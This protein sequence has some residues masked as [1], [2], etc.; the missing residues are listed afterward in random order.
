MP[1]NMAR[2]I[3]GETSLWDAGIRLMQAG[4]PE[5][6]QAIVDAVRIRRENLKA[7]TE[8][9][10]VADKKMRPTKCTIRVGFHNANSQ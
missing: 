9:E 7:I 5:E 10:R 6:W 4:N 1:E 8:C 2:H 3:V